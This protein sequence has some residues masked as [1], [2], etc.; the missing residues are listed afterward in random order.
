MLK[1]RWPEFEEKLRGHWPPEEL[2]RLKKMGMEGTC[3]PVWYAHRVLNMPI[4][5]AVREIFNPRFQ[6]YGFDFE[7][8]HEELHTDVGGY[9]EAAVDPASVRIADYELL[10]NLS[11]MA[12]LTFGAYKF[13]SYSNDHLPPNFHIVRGKGKSGKK[14][15]LELD[16]WILTNNYNWSNTDLNK[17]LE[18]A[19]EHRNELNTLWRTTHP[20]LR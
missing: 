4:K 13:Y 14:V 7:P 10:R 3:D 11:E 18:T 16:T 6:T 20:G 2:A 1:D 5:E 15:K 9:D 12:S 8:T 19:K 17:I